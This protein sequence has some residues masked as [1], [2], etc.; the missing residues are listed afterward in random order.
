MDL[1]ARR[2]INQLVAENW[3]QLLDLAK[4]VIDCR[5]ADGIFTPLNPSIFLLPGF[6]EFSK[7][8]EEKENTLFEAVKSLMGNLP[9]T[10][11]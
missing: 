1:N 11:G 5:L 4:V 10:D 7:E 3:Q 2:K 9:A 8:T 6:L